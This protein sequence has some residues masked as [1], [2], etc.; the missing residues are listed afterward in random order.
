VQKD[1]EALIGQGEQAQGGSWRL[2]K[3]EGI[4]CMER[5]KKGGGSVKNFLV[6]MCARIKHGKNVCRN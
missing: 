3:G 6:L 4:V 5:E 1:F 2:T